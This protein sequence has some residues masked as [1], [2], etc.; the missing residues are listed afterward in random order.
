MKT[1]NVVV[2]G[3]CT[4]YANPRRSPLSI[5]VHEDEKASFETVEE[6][7]LR[8]TR[9]TFPLHSELRVVSVCQN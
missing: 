2:E 9:K 8:I 3:I 5:L 1:W 6:A 7:A 4:S